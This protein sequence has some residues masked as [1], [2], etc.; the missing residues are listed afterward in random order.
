MTFTISRKALPGAP[1]HFP[2]FQGQQLG[3][4]VSQELATDE[5]KQ[6]CSQLVSL[7]ESPLHFQNSQSNIANEPP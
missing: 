1:S 3:P 7:P 2:H 6:L 4:S 5:S